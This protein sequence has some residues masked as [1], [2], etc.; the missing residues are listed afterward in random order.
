MKQRIQIAVRIDEETLKRVD[1]LVERVKWDATFGETIRRS[2]V[3]REAI[4]RGVDEL[5]KETK[6]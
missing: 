2:D 5:E 3:L 4:R 6:K 1:E